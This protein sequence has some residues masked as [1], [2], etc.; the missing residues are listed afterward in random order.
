MPLKIVLKPGEKIIVNQ[1]VIENGGEKAQ[2]ILQN[3]AVVL[4]ERDIMTEAKATSPARRIYF[5]VQMIYLFPEKERVHQENFNEL[6]RDFVHAVPSAA[7]I[8]AEIAEC[9]VE[10]NQYAALKRCRRLMEYEQE[11]LKHAQ[12]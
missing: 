8:A 7:P 5:T 4:R 2:L 1:A 6:L 9:L 3:R 10:G 11:V 12:R